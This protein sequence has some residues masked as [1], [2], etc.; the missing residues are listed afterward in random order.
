MV[1]SRSYSFPLATCGCSLG[2]CVQ[3]RCPK[4]TPAA[5]H[6]VPKPSPSEPLKGAF[7]VRKFA[8]N[9]WQNAEIVGNCVSHILDV[10]HCKTRGA[11]NVGNLAANFLQTP[12]VQSALKTPLCTALSSFRFCS[13]G[14]SHLVA[15]CHSNRSFEPSTSLLNSHGASAHNQAMDK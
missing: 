2:I 15:H 1:F 8:E 5:P 3:V 14:F 12:E 10:K 6:K 11:E 9:F 4:R 7:A 13:L